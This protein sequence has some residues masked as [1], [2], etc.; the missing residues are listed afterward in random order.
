MIFFVRCREPR[1]GLCPLPSSIWLVREHF[2]HQ[3]ASPRRRRLCLH[4]LFVSLVCFSS[5]IT[6]AATAKPNIIMVVVDQYRPDLIGAYGDGLN[7]STPNIDRLASEGLTFNNALSICP[8][9]TP[10]RAMVMSGRYG[11]HTGS[12]I[13]FTQFN[14]RQ[15]TI[16]RAFRD[17]GYMT[18]IIGKWHLAAGYL[19]EAGKFKPA[20]GSIETY[21]EKHPNF[22]FVPPGPERLGFE[23]WAAYNFHADFRH[24]QY[25][26]DKP[27]KLIMDGYETDAEFNMGMEFMREHQKD[28]QPFFLMITPH[29]PHPPF[30]PDHCPPGYLEKIPEKLVWSPNVPK[31]HPRRKNPLQMRCY[32]AMAKNFDDNVGRLLDF[33]D[34]SQLAANTIVIVTSDHGEMHGSHGR[35]DKMVPYAEAVRIPMII[36]WPGHIE[37]GR[38]TDTLQTPVDH[39]PTL[40]ALA[41]IT[42]T[43]TTDGMDLSSE[44][45][46]H[47]K[48]ERD[49]V[50]MMNYS[51]HWDYFQTGT[52]WPEWRGVKTKRYTYVKWLTGKEELYDDQLDPYQM[53]N[54]VES[55]AHQTELDELRSRLKKMLRAADDEFL[56]GTS[57]A[58]W[59]DDERNII[60]TG[61]GPVQP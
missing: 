48:I 31:D 21:R 57:Y 30:Q 47:G 1:S 19:K 32:L 26:R 18:G 16:A 33:L 9:C 28:H 4:T 52:N 27:E 61:L 11:S 50:L 8:L 54:L 46:G 53:R 58:N 2:M 29:P 23:F 14:P 55:A 45:L 51:S 43:A 3:S 60:G 49:A 41:G 38:H 40:C 39:F 7:I 10:Y 59:F 36:R 56:P 37:A 15:P 12:V 44:I 25:Y 20:P 34:Q 5:W 42:P 13:N 17:A 6:A 22:D 35:T 24:A